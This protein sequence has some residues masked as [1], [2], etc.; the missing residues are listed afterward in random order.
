MSEPGWWRIFAV[1]FMASIFSFEIVLSH[2][3]SE[4]KAFPRTK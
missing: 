1:A 2:P 3:I 4:Q